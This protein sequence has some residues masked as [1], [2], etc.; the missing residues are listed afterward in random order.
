MV[1]DG[2]QK[3]VRWQDLGEEEHQ[4]VRA[5]LAQMRPEE[6]SD[7]EREIYF[8]FWRKKAETSILFLG[9]LNG[10]IVALGCMVLTTTRDPQIARVHEVVVDRSCRNASTER[11]IFFRLTSWAGTM[12][13]AMLIEVD[14]RKCLISRE[15]LHEAMF[16]PIPSVRDS[17][18]W[19]CRIPSDEEK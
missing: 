11:E 6:R 17:H 9:C 10:R 7:A 15:I 8:N 5:L 4:A 16:H 14:D 18:L 3:P 12:T 1:F 13:S 19:R 2:L